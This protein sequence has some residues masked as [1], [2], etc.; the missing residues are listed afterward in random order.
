VSITI[1]PVNDAP[2]ATSRL[3]T[4][5][6]DTALSITLTGT[7]AEGDSLT[8]ALVSQP[9]HGQL[10][11]T[12]PN[13]VYTPATNYFGSDSL[14]FRVND[15]SLT[16]AVAT[17]N[18]VLTNVNDGPIA[19]SQ[20]LTNAE[21][22][23]FS[24][25]LAGVD[26]DGPVMNFMVVTNPIHGTLTGTPPNL[27]YLPATNYFGPDSFAFQVNDGSL[28][29]SVA[30][31]NITVTNVNDAPIALSQSL[32]N[33]EDTV[34]GVTL[35]GVD[36]D[37]PVMNFVV[38]TNP[39]HGT[40]TGTSPNLTYSP[41]TNYFGPDSFA[42]QVNDGS[43]VSSVATVS[44]LVTNV[45]DAPIALSQSL[46]NAEDAVLGI[47]LTGTD[48]DGP[49]MNF[50]VVTNPVHGTLTGAPPNLTYLPDTN[51]FGP[52]SFAFQVNDGSLFSGVASVSILVT[53]VDDPPQAF[54]DFLTRSMSQGVSVPV[55][56]LLTNDIDPDGDP[57]SVLSV[58]NALP[59]GATIT[60]S[61]NVVTYWPLFGDT[62]AGSFTYVITDGNSSA[63]GLVSVAVLPDPEASDILVITLTNQTSVQVTLTGVPG[64]TY[65][66]QRTFKMNPPDWDYLTTGIADE[67]G[68]ISIIDSTTNSTK[69]WYRTVRGVAPDEG[70]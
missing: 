38:V 28:V 46:T 14:K 5:P 47:T 30:M 48:L 56:T 25:T 59:A 53:N 2:V 44:F 12:P 1:T 67:L 49:V 36:P 52:D 23:A 7:D 58:S 57:L 27:T 54:P 70:P 24:I 61:N 9:S 69:R 3:L 41:D 33:A 11:G 21:D 60:L 51:Y 50:V 45:N 62:N 17:V 68:Q 4:T 20:S 18:I 32:T 66:V 26:L 65:T 15:G 64:F 43:L 35:T 42:F 22:T 13:L 31:V 16:S 34:L 19:L 8:F 40:L 6:E 39:V 10:T 29:S 63:T 37:G 55:A